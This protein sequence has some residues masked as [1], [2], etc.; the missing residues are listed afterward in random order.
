MIAWINPAAKI[1][2]AL[3]DMV[4]YVRTLDQSL[5]ELSRTSDL[6]AS[7]LQQ[8]TE[9]AH[10][11]GKTVAKTGAQTLDAIA[12]ARK[13]GYALDEAMRLAEESLK[14]TNMAA[15]I[16]DAGTAMD[17]LVQI[18]KN[19]KEDTSFTSTINDVISQIS[20]GQNISFDKLISGAKQLSA[21]ASQ[22]GVSF[23]QMIDTLTGAYQIIEDMEKAASGEA[24][25]FS[26][27]HP[28]QTTDEGISSAAR[29]QE[30]FAA[31]TN[32]A[33]NTLDQET[34]KLRNVY[35]ILSDLSIV[36]NT[37]DKNTRK[38]LA[39][40]AAGADQEAVFLALM[41]NWKNVE[42]SVQSASKSMGAAD[43]A[44]QKYLDSLT[45]KIAAFQ[46]AFH[47]LSATAVDSDLLKFFVDLGTT[48]VN[49]INRLM[50][51]I[52][53]FGALGGLS[54][55][56]LSLKNVGRRKMF[57]LTNMPTAAG[58]LPDT[59]VFLLPVMKYIMVNEGTICEE[60]PTLLPLSHPGSNSAALEQFAGTA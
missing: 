20:G 45:G 37:L 54:G 47:Q 56:A 40:E 9:R 52:S 38:S 14:M 34:K 10:E 41:N 3:K 50:S 33:V 46:S 35:D 13:S 55:I 15:G 39:Q 25:I 4:S 17:N 53:S 5:L 32:G 23:E 11:L 21:A 43:A 29:L 12:S 51:A 30:T 31:A 49:G 16:S 59:E 18:I 26:R 42:I 58:V 28:D 48:G 8:I 7:Q 19:F 22:S 36:W 24:A 2:E 1:T 60:T 27:L 57:R 6:S 44:N